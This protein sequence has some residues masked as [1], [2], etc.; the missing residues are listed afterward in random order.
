MVIRPISG[1]GARPDR[2][3]LIALS[4]ALLQT[5]VPARIRIAPASR[6]S[7]RRPGPAFNLHMAS[8][9][10][11]LS[12]PVPD[13]VTACGGCRANSGQAA[14][15]GVLPIKLLPQATRVFSKACVGNKGLG[16]ARL[17]RTK[18]RTFTSARVYTFWCPGTQ[19]WRFWVL[20][21]SS[22]PDLW[23]I[24]PVLC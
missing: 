22:E 13:A 3:R 16:M 19:G 21:A 14:I 23:Q 9:A 18:H 8:D 5:T 6:T 12:S 4:V 11:M 10:H 7:A 1:E 2:I 24:K 17:G 15:L 20:F